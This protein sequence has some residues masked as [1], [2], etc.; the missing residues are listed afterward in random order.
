MVKIGFIVEGNTEKIIIDSPQFKA[1]LK[2][3][4]LFAVE[5]I[6]DANGNGNLL[7]QKIIPFI[8]QL[9]KAG[10]DKIVV[11]TDS[12]NNTIAQVKKRILP[13]NAPY[14]IDLIVVAVKAIE[15]WFLACEDIMKTVLQ[16]PDF[17]IK[18]PERTSEAPFDYIKK[19][20]ASRKVRGPGAKPLFA[21]RVLKSGFSLQQAA[22]HPNCPSAALFLKNLYQI[23]KYKTAC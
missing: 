5:P 3:I 21:K 14:T 22:H 9:K 8:N 12:D 2:N 1:F 10:A 17:S 18:F 13:K 7:P 16:I 6:I 19:L 23:A 15:A 11:I 20:T 4:G